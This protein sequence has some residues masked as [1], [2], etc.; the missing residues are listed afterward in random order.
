MH[1]FFVNNNQIDKNKIEINGTDVNHIKN[2]LRLKI[3]DKLQI[4]N[5]ETSEN[6]ITKIVS[7][8]EEKVESEIIEELNKNIETTFD[9]DI[10][11]GLPKFDKMEFIIQKTTEIGVKKIIPVSMERCVV[12][13]NEKDANKKIE[14]WKKIAEIA[15]KQS[16]RDYIPIIEDLINI[17]MVCEKIK[18]YDVFLV[19][20]EDEEEINLKKVIKGNTNA[21]KIGV[22]IGPEGGID[23]K[24]IEKLKQNGAKI[25]TLRQK[26]FKNR[27]STNCCSS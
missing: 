12:K 21:K 8:S 7:L 15:A 6:Y 17:N 10:Y 11:Q 4:C 19:A 2:V 16:K 9:I 27:N 13:L 20:Y 14:R 3:D 24:E 1:K 26:N 5:K 18:D 23:I 25:V 22:L